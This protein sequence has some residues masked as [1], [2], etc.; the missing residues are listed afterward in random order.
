MTGTAI[1]SSYPIA[2]F[3]GNRCNDV[4]YFGFCS[5]L[6]VMVPPADKLDTI[7]IVPPNI[8]RYQSRVRI[9]TIVN[10]RIK[11]ATKDTNTRTNLLKNR[12]VEFPVGEHEIGI[13]HSNEPVLVNSFAGGSSKASVYGDPF[14]ITI[15]GINQYLKNYIYFVPDGYNFSFATFII[16]NESLRN[17]QINSTDIDVDTCLFHSSV[18]IGTAFFSVCTV[19]VPSGVIEVKTSDRS[20][21]GFI[22]TGQRKFDGYGYAGNALL[23]TTCGT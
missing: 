1:N 2:V 23:T 17:L 10:T 5:L 12:F 22:V 7:F 15:P 3:A 8:H 4:G 16:R 11:Y 19:S 14:M 20:R 9:L 6:V 13:I 21:F 18:L